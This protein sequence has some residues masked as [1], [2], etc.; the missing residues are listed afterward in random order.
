M[1]GRMCVQSHTSPEKACNLNANHKI[2]RTTLSYQLHLYVSFSKIYSPTSKY[3]FWQSK[4]PMH[5][6][7]SNSLDFL[8]KQFSVQNK[9]TK[10]S[11]VTLFVQRTFSSKKFLEVSR[12]PYKLHAQIKPDYTFLLHNSLCLIKICGS[13]L[14]T[15]NKLSSHQS[16]SHFRWC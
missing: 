11:I 10:G 7:L 15:Q 14:C 13:I 1:S 8:T 9:I 5:T 12:R 6:P 2:L 16:S 3:L 4:Q